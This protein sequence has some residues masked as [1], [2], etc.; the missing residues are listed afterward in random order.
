MLSHSIRPG[1]QD[2]ESY[3]TIADPHEMLDN[4]GTRIMIDTEEPSTSPRLRKPDFD[5]PRGAL[6]DGRISLRR[7]GENRC[8]GSRVRHKRTT[9][10]WRS[11]A[12]G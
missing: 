5:C 6:P 11:R 9:G 7:R 12:L 10:Y 4:A 2:G 1:E 3:R 8:P